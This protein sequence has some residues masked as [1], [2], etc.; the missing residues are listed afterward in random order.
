MNV[1][2]S[3]DSAYTNG[4]ST[5]AI[6]IP[7]EKFIL[8]VI[9]ELNCPILVSSANQS[10]EKQH[11]QVMMCMNSL[12]KLMVLYLERVKRYRQVRLLTVQKKSYKS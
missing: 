4:L 9:D 11:L 8:D 3:V 6:R 12:Q 5:I 10:G 1:K 2:D 7:D